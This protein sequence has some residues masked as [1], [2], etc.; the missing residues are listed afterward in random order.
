MI[1]RCDLCTSAVAEWGVDRF[2]RRWCISCA[3]VV[4]VGREQ[5]AGRAGYL[6]PA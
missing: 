6:W 2:G 4:Q 1:A 3:T 5:A